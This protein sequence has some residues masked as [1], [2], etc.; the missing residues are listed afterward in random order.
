[1]ENTEAKQAFPR[2]KR[3]KDETRDS[4]AIRPRDRTFDRKCA[5]P[6]DF[7]ATPGATVERSG[8]MMFTV[9]IHARAH[10]EK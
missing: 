4:P 1:M 3:E 5:T 7:S 9:N 8:A 2:A 6:L 10:R